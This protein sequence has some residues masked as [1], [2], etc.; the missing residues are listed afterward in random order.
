MKLYESID[1]IDKIYLITEYLEGKPLSKYMETE[2][3]L[4]WDS[5]FKVF[6]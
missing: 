1:T 4:E 2:G 5:I 3:R 6:K